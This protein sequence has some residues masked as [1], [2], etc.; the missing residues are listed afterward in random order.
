MTVLCSFTLLLLL[1]LLLLQEPL[2]LYKLLTNSTPA[3]CEPT[4]VEATDSSQARGPLP[5]LSYDDSAFLLLIFIVCCIKKISEC[6]I[7]LSSPH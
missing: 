2:L 3:A 7:K 5:D 4:S 6:V 1:M